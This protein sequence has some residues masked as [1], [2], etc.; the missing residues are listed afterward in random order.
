MSESSETNSK[1]YVYDNVEVVM[2]G[3][4]AKKERRTTTR[5]TAAAPSVLYEITPA[6]L[7]S[8]SWKKWVKMSDLYEIVG[9]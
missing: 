9:D 8:G 6:N 5:R 1:K 7:E 3:R 2:T 4:T